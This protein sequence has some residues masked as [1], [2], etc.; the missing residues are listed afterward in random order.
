VVSLPGHLEQALNGLASA[1]LGVGVTVAARAAVC[2]L[3]ELGDLLQ[4]MVADEGMAQRARLLGAS[5]HPGGSAERC[6]DLLEELVD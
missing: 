6:A 3:Q 5:L 4:R 1:R 2:A